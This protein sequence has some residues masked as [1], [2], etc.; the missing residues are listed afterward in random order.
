MPILFIRNHTYIL[1]DYNYCERISN[2]CKNPEKIKLEIKK[3][4]K[5]ISKREISKQQ[6]PE[7]KYRNWK[8][9]TLKCSFTFTL[10]LTLPPLPSHHSHPHPHSYAHPHP[11][12][13]S[14]G[15]SKFELFEFLIFRDFAF[16]D[17]FSSVVISRFIFS[18]FLHNTVEY[19]AICAYRYVLEYLVER[20]WTPVATRISIILY[21]FDSSH[22]ALSECIKK[23]L[24]SLRLVGEVELG[25]EKRAWKK[26]KID[27]RQC[28]SRS[29]VLI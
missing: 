23:F 3:L 1:D 5:Q 25:L 24:V 4:E 29:R 13:R 10:T 9:R 7:K 2:C 6:N 21:S 12:F 28:N 14:I 22:Y 17:F 19:R 15:F 26:T 16:R 8:S 11:Q 27:N 18:G 20:I